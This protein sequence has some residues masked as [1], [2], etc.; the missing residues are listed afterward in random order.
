[1]ERTAI[2]LSLR[3]LFAHEP[4]QSAAPDS[5]SALENLPKPFVQS[6]LSRKNTCI[7]Y[8]YFYSTYLLNF[9]SQWA[10]AGRIQTNIVQALVCQKQLIFSPMAQ[11]R[12]TQ[13]WY[14]CN[15]SQPLTR[16]QP[17]VSQH[18]TQSN[19]CITFLKFSFS[20]YLSMLAW[21]SQNKLPAGDTLGKLSLSS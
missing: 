20:N 3:S 13:Q 7:K 10:S 21:I 16:L 4:P 9:S 1:M 12:I 8:M 17:L 6:M 18:V 11:T 15:Q 5:M 14:I 2:I 19:H